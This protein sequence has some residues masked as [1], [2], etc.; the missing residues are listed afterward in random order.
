MGQL[1]TANKRHKRAIRALQARDTSEK[2][3]SVVTDKP[4]KA[5]VR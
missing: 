5:P 3:V 1:R 2:G 4:V